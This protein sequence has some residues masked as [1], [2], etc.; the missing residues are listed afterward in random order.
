MTFYLH[1]QR[2]TGTGTQTLCKINGAARCSDSEEGDHPVS[3]T[4]EEDKAATGQTGPGMLIHL[5]SRV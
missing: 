5:V 2:E 1:T 3:F 4:E